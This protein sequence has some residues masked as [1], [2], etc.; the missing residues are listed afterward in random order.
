MDYS[1]EALDG[2]T[3]YAFGDSIVYGHKTPS[4]SLMR[5]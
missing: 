3:V 4:Q 2:K 1:Y 5:R